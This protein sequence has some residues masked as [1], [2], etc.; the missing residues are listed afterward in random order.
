MTTTNN[1]QSFFYLES[2]REFIKLSQA[3]CCYVYYKN[4]RLNLCNNKKEQF[5][6]NNFLDHLDDIKI[7]QLRPRPKVIHLFYELSFLLYNLDYLLEGDDIYAIEIDYE[8]VGKVNIN[9]ENN[10]SLDPIS[11]PDKKQYIDSFNL[12]REHLLKGNCY[13]FNLTY[14]FDF[15]IKNFHNEYDIT[16]SVFYNKEKVGPFAHSTILPQLGKQFISNSPE[17][18]FKINKYKNYFQ[19]QSMPIKG[20]INYG[21][22]EDFQNKWNE[23]I[24][25]KKNESELFMI[26]DLIKNDLSKIEG[27][28]AEVLSLKLPLTVPGILHQY[29]LLSVDLSYKV[30]LKKLVES[31]F[32]GGSI[33]G[34]P[35]KRVIKILSELE[36]YKRGFY[37]GATIFLYQDKVS[38]SINIRSAEVMSNKNLLRYSAGG[39]ITL[40]SNVNDEYEEMKMKVSSFINLLK[41]NHY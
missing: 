28:I 34:A 11:L 15:E 1:I 14:P 18:L 23:L 35:K 24:N 3:Q 41:T 7:N 38:A 16:N 4:Y 32:P 26:T 13:Q 6:F 9:H 29:S 22:N 10:I 27:P 21:K 19:L 30:T 20:S 36:N 12:G 39:G 2:I 17:C 25:S 33:T 31:L 40:K 5:V 37:C 8:K